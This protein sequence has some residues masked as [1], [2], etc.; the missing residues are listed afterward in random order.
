MMG[1]AL[2]GVAVM[3][4][5]AAAVGAAVAAGACPPSGVE[6]TEKMEPLPVAVIASMASCRVCP[7][8]AETASA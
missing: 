7:A 5:V 6:T 1:V 2:G 4:S 8:V 3:S